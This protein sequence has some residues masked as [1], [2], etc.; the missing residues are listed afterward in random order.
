MRKITT[1]QL[2]KSAKRNILLILIPAI[3]LFALVF[4]KTV[5]K[6]YKSYKST[7][8]LMVT[9][10]SKDQAISY[11][12]IILNEKLANIY[13]GF[14]ESSDLYSDVGKK[15]GGV[16]TPSEIKANLEYD[17]NPQGGVISFTFSD[18]NADRAKD[19]L[20][21]I[22]EE[23]R[24]YALKLLNMDNINYLQKPQLEK[25]SLTKGIIFSMAGLFAGLL[26]GILLSILKEI[27]SD[28]I[29]D[30]KDIEDMG[31]RVLGNIYEDEKACIYTTKSTINHLTENAVI[32][33]TSINPKK[34]TYDFSEKLAQTM[35]TSLG[36]CLIDSM[37]ENK[38][39]EKKYQSSEEDVKILR[40][41]DMD[42]IILREK[43]DRILDSYAFEEKIFDLKNTY[44]Y[45][46][47]NE[48]SLRGL[49]PI[50]S[51][52]YE[53][54]KIVVVNENIS[55]EKL[56]RKIKA[57]EDMGCKVLG[58]IYDK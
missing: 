28:R 51:L 15:M 8:M 5:I 4:Y 34:S 10:Q 40:Y 14:L 46:L 42:F 30:E 9:G 52:R 27:L 18:T 13:S 38:N 32:G 33:I 44:N 47:I 54:Y 39:V 6:E 45:V 56:I 57:I 7:A 1:E 35:S 24:N 25:Y 49:G 21:L 11:N 37:G 16:L 20:T 36:L 31:L 2:L 12:N 53:D 50:I 26:L 58:V 23:F 17:V 48:S 19:C 43:S 29:R 22:T 41:K 55:M 3:L